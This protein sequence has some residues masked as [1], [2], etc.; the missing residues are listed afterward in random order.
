[1]SQNKQ[2]ADQLQQNQPKAAD[3]GEQKLQSQVD[4][5]IGFAFRGEEPKDL[6]GEPAVTEDLKKLFT[7]ILDTVTAKNY[8]KITKE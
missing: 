7:E 6:H 4:M 5:P 3:G 1:M 2:V 8:P